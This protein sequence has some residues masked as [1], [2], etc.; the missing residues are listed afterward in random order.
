M[1]FVLMAVGFA[2]VL[3]SAGALAE[4][5]VLVNT[6]AKSIIAQQEEIRAEAVARKGRYKDMDERTIRDLLAKQDKVMDLL[7]GKEHSTELS[8]ID[9]TTLFNS[10]ESIEAI[11]NK[12]EDERMVCR[13]ERT[14]GSHRTQNVCKTVAQLRT[15]REQGQTAIGARDIRCEGCGEGNGGR[16]EAW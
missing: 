12:A 13:R 2:A 16:P 9:Q 5:P 11:V 15:E 1:K 14:T 10:L 6:D 3:A 7:D 4:Q 8:K